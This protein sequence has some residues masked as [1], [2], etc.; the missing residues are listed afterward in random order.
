MD[1]RGISLRVAAADFDRMLLREVL[2]EARKHLSSEVVRKAWVHRS[3]SQ[4]EFVVN[5]G[6]PGLEEGFYW[7]G[8]AGSAYD[9]KAQGFE[10]LLRSK[11]IEA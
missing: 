3:G 2:A 5:E 6:T 4:W 11:G 7:N 10:A 9:A 1:A 8:Q